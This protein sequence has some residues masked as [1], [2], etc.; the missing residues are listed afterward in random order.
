MAERSGLLELYG[1]TQFLTERVLYFVQQKLRP[2][3]W[4]HCVRV[5]STDEVQCGHM[6][7]WARSNNSYLYL[8][9]GKLQL[10][11]V[12]RFKAWPH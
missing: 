5:Q 9:L 7:G 2:Q 11:L 4:L 1:W 12:V 10:Q 8:D 3:G 6:L